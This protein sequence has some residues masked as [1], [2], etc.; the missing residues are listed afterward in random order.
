VDNARAF[1]A[2]KGWTVAD[3]HVYVDDGISGA[4]FERRPGF[5]RLL[6]AL[7]PSP[8]Y[9]VLIVSER[10]SLG[11][12]SYETGY[13]I[14]QIA[15]AGVAIV[16]YVHGAS[17]TPRNCLE[18]VVSDAKG[19][20]DELHREDTEELGPSAETEQADPDQSQTPRAGS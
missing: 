11:R 10:K 2:S 8:S 3:Q 15:R 5:M 20:A 7:E 12:E 9:E 19:W 6:A 18:K 17:L 16:E 1:A 4:E 13:R 14:K